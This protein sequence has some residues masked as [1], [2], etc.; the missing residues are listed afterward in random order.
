MMRG[1]PPR[2]SPE[3]RSALAVVPAR[4]VDQP[5][6]VARSVAGQRRDRD[7]SAGTAA[8]TNHRGPA[9]LRPGLRLRRRHGESGFVLEDEPGSTR[10]RESSGQGH[11]SLPHPATASSSR[12][13]ARRPAPGTTSRC[14]PEASARPESC[15]QLEAP[16]DQRLDPG[17]RPSLFLPAVRGQARSASSCVNCFWLSLGSDAGPCDRS[18]RGP[19]PFHVRRHRRTDRTPTRRSLAISARLT[20][21][22]PLRGLEP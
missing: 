5:W 7:A 14:A 16:T 22:E 13:M 1:R 12:S 6:A 20:P 8:E 4:P 10:R 19:P 11:T 2:R 9:A 21:S 17:E 18:A 3:R 15:G